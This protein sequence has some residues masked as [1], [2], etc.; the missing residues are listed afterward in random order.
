M[1]LWYITIASIKLRNINV[2]LYCLFINALQD[3]FVMMIHWKSLREVT[4]TGWWLM[5]LSDCPY[6]VKGHDDI[7]H[8]P[9]CNLR[10]MHVVAEC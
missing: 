7:G 4:I 6:K 1:Y 2:H 10:I 8:L 5:V 9:E 3:E